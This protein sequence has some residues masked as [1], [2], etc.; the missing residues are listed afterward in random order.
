MSDTDVLPLFS[1]AYRNNDL[2]TS[3]TAAEDTTSC[4][5]RFSQCESIVSALVSH[6]TDAPARG[7]TFAEIACLLGWPH[8]HV[9]KRMKDC[10]R[11]GPWSVRGALYRVRVGAPR[12]CRRRGTRC[13]TYYV[14]RAE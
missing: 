3:A 6:D 10:Q 1:Q 4:G 11:C 7:R 8:D 9:H 14:E 2:P 13:R 12:T 5:K